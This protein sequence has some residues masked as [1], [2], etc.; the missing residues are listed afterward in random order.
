[1]S[2]RG[3][4]LLHFLDRYCGI[5]LLA[6]LSWPRFFK[7]WP[8]LPA[9]FEKI[10]VFCPGAI[11][12]LLLGSA[13]LDGLRKKAP[14]A[15]LELIASHANAQ[16]ARLLPMLDNCRAFSITDI[17]GMLKYI[18]AQK[19]DIF[20]DMCQWSRL[21]ALLAFFSG[22][23]LKAG[24]RTPGQ[25]RHLPYDIVVPHS[26]TRHELEN[27][28]ELGLAL[29][30]D[31]SGKPNLLAPAPAQVTGK[32]LCC[33]LWPAPGANS[34]LRQ[35]PESHWASLILAL[36]GKYRIY[37][38]GGRADLPA[39]LDF[40][41][42]HF[43]NDSQVIVPEPMPLIDLAALFRAACAV[44]S[45]NTGVMHLAALLGVPTI[46]LH[47]PTSIQRWGPIGS[48]CLGLAPDSGQHGYL[49]LGF[50]YPP[51]AKPCM[52][53]LPVEKVLDALQKL[54]AHMPC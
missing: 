12:D 3:N 25:F 13:L 8:T 2:E 43:A 37:L 44:I 32:V 16:A 27:F 29:W 18:R 54:L 17:G 46:G 40:K 4:R 23:R 35:W 1:M 49:N 9:R 20:I 51:N 50:E 42:R 14:E 30:P 28:L 6:A 53:F 7:A 33:H 22:A 48:H 11:G 52:Q 34:L 41:R 36:K 45:V 21:G 26:A 47:G 19:Y 10:G 5:P 39:N 24:F 31:F 38:T 15:R